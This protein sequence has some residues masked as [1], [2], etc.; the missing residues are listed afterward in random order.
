MLAGLALL[1]PPARAVEPVTA[2]VRVHADVPTVLR[3]LADHEATLR[4]CPDVRSVAVVRTLA[5]GC[6]ELEVETTGFLS[7]MRYRSRRCPDGAGYTEAL[8]SSD[9]FTE[10]RFTWS[11]VDEGAVRRVTLAVR[12]E[13]SLPVPGWIVA[14]AVR[15]SVDQ[16]VAAFAARVDG[17]SAPAGK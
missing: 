2:S 12:S 16:T 14:Q 15:R 5:G 7:P 8:T 10:N 9:D 11:V 13:P 3:A 1:S 17:A 4:V 6:A